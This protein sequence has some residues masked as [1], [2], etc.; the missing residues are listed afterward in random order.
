V[1]RPTPHAGARLLGRRRECAALDRLLDDVRAGPSSAL[2][3]R[4]EAGVGKSALLAYVEERALG[5]R[6]IRASGV[7]SEME[8]AF[9][10]VHLLC[11]P[12]LDRLERLAGPQ[13][14]A[15]ATAFALRTGPVPDRFVVSLAVLSLLSEAA[16]ERPLVCLIDD[17]QWL[18]H[19]SIQV[20]GFVAR[21]LQRESVA[22]LFAL[23]EPAEAP[24]LATLPTLVLAGLADADATE[25]LRSVVPGPLDD[26]V[27]DRIVAEMRG[28]PLG[29]LELPRDMSEQE[30]AGGFGT[31]SLRALPSGVEESFHRRLAAL[32][33]Q[34]RG[35]LL[36]AAAEPL[37]QP[38]LLWRAA[39][40]Q[41]IPVGAA[42]PAAEAGLC[43]FGTSILFRHP[44]VRAAAYR[45]ASPDERRGAH[46]ALAEATDADADPDRRAWHRAL[47][48][49]G[50]D[51]AV[52]D[53]LERSAAGA[54]A[55][56][57][58]AA[59][60]AFL[61][62]SMELTRDPARRAER[63]LAAAEAMYLS[64]AAEPALRLAAVAQSGPLDE[65]RHIR[66][67][68]LRGQVATMQ[69]RGSDAP[70]LLLGAA[71]RLDRL[72]HRLARDTYRDAY[73]AAYLAGRLAGGTGL[74]EVATALRAAPR[75]SE[76]A[77]VTDRLLDAA[78]LLVVAGH[79]VGASE[80]RQA[81]DAVRTTPLP[82]DTELRWLG[83]ACLLA[84]DVWDEQAWDALS[85]RHIDVVQDA[86]VL[87]L[88][89]LPISMRVGLDLFA[90]DLEVATQRIAQADA[91]LAA[92]SYPSHIALAAFQGAETEVAQLDEAT[93]QDAV[94]RSDGK[95]LTVRDWS[96][97]V[98]C[99][100]LGQYDKA[101]AA[102]QQAV[103][104]RDD[105]GVANWALPELVEAAARCGRPDETSDALARLGAMAQA[106]RT[107]W[108]LGVEARARALVADRDSA[109]GLHR[110]AIDHL[111]R[112][113]LRAELA[114]AHLLY[115]EWLRRERR[116]VDAREQLRAAHAT[117][118][119]IG[120]EA[121]AERARGELRA[122]G[123]RVRKRT[124]E[125][126]DQLTPQERQIA[127]LARDRLSNPEIGARLF[128]SPRTV[129]WHLRNVFTKLGIKS[130]RQLAT[131]LPSSES[132][133]AP[134]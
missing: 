5:C 121:F 33:E 20:L 26:R 67:D 96:T 66:V 46:A 60:A 111:K 17:V 127:V 35:L 75:S 100:G 132:E 31:G 95:W 68:A 71:Q 32:S 40:R 99:N 102:A 24:D 2:V 104:Y 56:G 57:G 89:P 97:A 18:D 38:V 28:N 83:L 55:R 63:A 14:D 116:R 29:V 94:A 91:V 82:V 25:L 125:T 37:G 117:L 59:A 105:G 45:A 103:A 106:C 8:L 44:L 79:A 118:A 23:R 27:R 86:G 30:L 9:A 48:A 34:T 39:D 131:A 129:E 12:M 110:T 80:V 50:P 22:M 84:V 107:D 11:S 93:T 126:R 51:D 108:I 62:R 58:Q 120:M 3:F 92:Q 41:G 85:A 87:A 21:R 43:E 13:R 52:A 133:P 122:T 53:E 7:E 78:A 88:L 98:L 76:A 61:D 15:L 134:A 1:A 113:R 19:T 73:W 47:A 65:L 114:R 112:T 10:G 130:R 115:G 124:V 69:R 54:R 6:V 70:P 119:D 123:E 36:L 64:G 4:G 109:E 101:L 16:A 42:T 74:R 49:A 72:G 77:G 81:L 90:G 128:L